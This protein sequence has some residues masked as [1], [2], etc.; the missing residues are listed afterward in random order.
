M[1]L[2]QAFRGGTCSIFFFFCEGKK[3]TFTALL[4]QFSGPD[5]LLCGWAGRTIFGDFALFFF[6]N[7]RSALLWQ[8]LGL[9]LFMGV[10][11]LFSFV[12]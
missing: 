10:T 9:D 11:L 2:D 4:W 3:C 8:F 12:C 6:V 1:G 5:F 7:I